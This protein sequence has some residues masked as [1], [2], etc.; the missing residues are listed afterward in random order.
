MSIFSRLSEVRFIPR[1]ATFLL[2]AT[3][4]LGLP[5][6]SRTAAGVRCLSTL[7][8]TFVEFGLSRRWRGF[9]IDLD[10]EDIAIVSRGLSVLH[11]GHALFA[12]AHDEMLDGFT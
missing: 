12:H 7:A 5:S 6:V 10:D 2:A 11:I 8:T 1:L 3:G 4:A 9:A